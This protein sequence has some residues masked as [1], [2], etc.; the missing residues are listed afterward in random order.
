M[1]DDGTALV[2]TMQVIS[3]ISTM[4]IRS[5]NSEFQNKYGPKSFKEETVDLYKINHSRY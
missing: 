4:P 3:Y 2:Y 5:E 1:L